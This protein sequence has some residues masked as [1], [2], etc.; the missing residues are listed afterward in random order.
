MTQRVPRIEDLTLDMLHPDKFLKA[1]HLK[2]T[3]PVVEIEEVTLEELPM[4][5]GKKAVATVIAFKGKQKRLV[6]CKTNSTA[7]AVLLGSVR[8]SDWI[9]KRVQLCADQD[10]NKR[11]KQLEPC[12]RVLGSPD[13]TKEGADAYAKAWRGDRTKGALCTRLK[14]VIA[15][16]QTTN[17][18]PV[19]QDEPTPPEE[20]SAP[21]LPPSSDDEWGQS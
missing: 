17:L 16:M 7:I 8:V 2:G 21:V 19:E 1:H 3:N 15:R 18:A 11:T 4:E 5:R 10:V 6:S 12:I 14:L 9:G 13:A 20:E